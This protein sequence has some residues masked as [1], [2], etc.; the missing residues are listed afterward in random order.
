MTN[1]AIKGFVRGIPELGSDGIF[2]IPV[3]IADADPKDDYFFDRI[4][5]T[6]RLAWRYGADGGRG[7]PIFDH[8]HILAYSDLTT[9]DP[10]TLLVSDIQLE[11]PDASRVLLLQNY[12]LN[13]A[14]R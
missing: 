9:L 5:Q 1:Y 4:K 8:D 14:K 12:V 7:L 10:D 3:L 11:D 2:Y 13:A 6:M